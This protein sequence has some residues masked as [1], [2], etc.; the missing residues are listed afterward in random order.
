MNS[1]QIYYQLHEEIDKAES[2]CTETSA[3]ASNAPGNKHEVIY[4]TCRAA[5]FAMSAARLTL[6]RYPADINDAHDWL[7]RAIFQLQLAQRKIRS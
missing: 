2:Q 7:D 1:A 3:I 4:H 5:T 6:Q